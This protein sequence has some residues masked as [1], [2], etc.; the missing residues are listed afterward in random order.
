MAVLSSGYALL[1]GGGPERAAAVIVVIGTVLAFVAE[2]L[3]LHPYGSIAVGMFLL[4]L[5]MLIAFQSLA[6]AADRFWTTWVAGLQQAAVLVH[7]TRAI[8]PDIAPFAYAVGL[9]G[10]S[11]VIL[12]LIIAGTWRHR[13]RLQ[14][15]GSDRCWSPIRW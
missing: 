14:I 8:A 7:I 1:Y 5:A 11:Y 6:L 12:I 3:G 15:Y 9:K 13:R 4:D 2:P 10:W